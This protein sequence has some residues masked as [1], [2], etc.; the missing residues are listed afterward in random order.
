MQTPQQRFV[1]AT[2]THHPQ[3]RRSRAFLKTNGAAFTKKHISFAQARLDLGGFA[4]FQSSVRIWDGGIQHFRTRPAPARSVSPPHM[5]QD[6][7]RVFSWRNVLARWP[8]GKSCRRAQA[9]QKPG[10]LP[11]RRPPRLSS[12]GCVP[13][14]QRVW[15]RRHFVRA[16]TLSSPIWLRVCGFGSNSPNARFATRFA[17]KAKSTSGSDHVWR[18]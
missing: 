15:S 10:R 9:A 14:S 5:R 18:K 2:R 13:L 3:Y 8:Q 7:P 4:V 1:V 12:R 17:S 16:R 6:Y 11:P